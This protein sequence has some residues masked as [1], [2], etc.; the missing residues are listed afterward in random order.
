MNKLV[1]L[2]SLALVGSAHAAKWDKANNPYYFN[3]VAQTKLTPQF[4]SLPLVAKIKDD[5]YGWSE[6]YWPANKGG[7]AYRWNH[8]NPENFKYRL[9]SKEELMK[10][11]E[12]ELS[13]LSPAELYDIAQGDYSYK[14]TRKV[15]KTNKPTD[16]WWEGIC[17][18]WALAASN[19][20][21][22][23]KVVVTNKDGVKVPFGS[24]DVKAL[25]ALHD[26]YNS[27]GFNVRVGERCSANGKVPGEAVHGK[28]KNVH[29]PTEKE[30][31]TKECM[32]VNA[33]A[34]HIV[35]TNMIG[36]NSHGFVAEIDRYNDVW[37]QPVT[38]YESQIVEEVSLTPTD[39]ANG[40]NRKVRM[41]T[42]M[43]FAEELVFETPEKVAQGVVGFVS[44]DPVTGTPA[45]TFLD[46]KYDYILELDLQGNIIGGE[47]ISE[48]RP[49]F[50]W[51][52]ARET[53][54]RNGKYDLSGLSKIYQPVQH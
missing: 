16:L 20:A 14:L 26:A 32:D 53:Q 12:N 25:L 10:M 45:Q 30:K 9:H 6:S 28:D 48:S 1:V 46:R 22:P 51:L 8:P 35:L 44:K 7:V 27:K 50:I 17:H 19:Y 34:F 39:L 41:K 38:G 4:S 15:L 47:W 29:E 11:S 43:I 54:F 24:S 21:E 33:G 23:A 49:D 36:I 42:T 5:R 3:N 31:N 13:M 18:G 37:N 40:V 52:K 2:A